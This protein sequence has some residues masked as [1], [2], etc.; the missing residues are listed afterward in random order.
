VSIS[1]TF[2]DIASGQT[3]T[4]FLLE[5]DQIVAFRDINPVAL[6]H[7]LIVSKEHI[8]SAG[9]VHEGHAQLLADV[10]HAADRLAEDAGFETYRLV[11]NVGE[12]GTQAIK[13]FHFHVLA[14]RDFGQPTGLE[15]ASTG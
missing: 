6:F 2:C 9:E 12:H 5:T 8:R 7:L 11:T 4:E 15:Q 10:F 14:G 13:H 1:C 3:D